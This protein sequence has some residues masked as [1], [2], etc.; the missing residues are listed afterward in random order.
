MS[1]MPAE[2]DTLGKMRELYAHKGGTFSCR[3]PAPASPPPSATGRANK[4]TLPRI[5][6]DGQRQPCVGINEFGR[7]RAMVYAS[8]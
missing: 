1:Y 8:L 2:G 3:A 5:R 6:S 7:Q 4:S